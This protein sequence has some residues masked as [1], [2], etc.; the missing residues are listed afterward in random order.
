MRPT[1]ELKTE[2]GVI[3]EL[4]MVMDSIS[5]RLESGEKV[6]PQHLLLVV[7]LIREYADQGHHAKEEGLLFPALEQAGI[8]REGGPLGMMEQEHGMGRQLVGAMEEAAGR[9]ARGDRDAG[10]DFA[11]AARNYV[12]LLSLH[13]GK[14]NDILFP[15]ADD[16]LSTEKQ[17]ELEAAFREAQ[18]R[19]LGPERLAGLMRTLDMLKEVYLG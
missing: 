6:E 12:G 4:L 3:G 19:E 17:A 2:H 10:L 9:Y 5:N 15:M 11:Q 18:V 8:P 16:R 13:I 14:E 7:R 1:E